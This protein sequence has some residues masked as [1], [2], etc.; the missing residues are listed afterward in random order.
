MS[1]HRWLKAHIMVGTTTNIVTSVEVTDS[2]VSDTRMLPALLE[3]NAR[4]ITMRRVSADKG[5]LSQ[6]I[7]AH[8]AEPFVPFKVNTAFNRPRAASR[9]KN[10]QWERMLHYY[11]FRRDEFLHHYHRRSN[12]ETTFRMIK[13]KFGGRIAQRL[14]MLPPRTN[15]LQGLGTQPVRYRS[16][17]LRTWNRSELLA[18]AKRMM[19]YRWRPT[20]E[21]L[22]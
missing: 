7:E 1:K 8:G 22:K 12:V 13:A 15:F 3:S 9:K 19:P 11:M 21:N 18:I 4:R 16:I 2:N 5:Y 6:K 17:D 10:V 14:R 20:S